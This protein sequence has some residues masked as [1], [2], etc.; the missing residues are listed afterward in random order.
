MSHKK[1]ICHYFLYCAQGGA[2]GLL[3]AAWLREIERHTLIPIAHMASVVAGASV[4]AIHAAALTLRHPDHPESPAYSAEDY[5]EIFKEDLPK[6]LPHDPW[7]YPRQVLRTPIHLAAQYLSRQARWMFGSSEQSPPYKAHYSTDYPETRLSTLFNGARVSDALT[8]LAISAHR[9]SPYPSTA[10]DFLSLPKD[11]DPEKFYHAFHPG[12]SEA[13]QAPF[14]ALS[15]IPLHQAVMASIVCPTIFKSYEIPGHGI[16]TDMGGVNSPAGMISALKASLPPEDDIHF[17][18]LG[19]ASLDR[20]IDPEHYNRSNFLATITPMT[21]MA[22]MHVSSQCLQAL[23][24]VIGAN[25]VT[26][27][28]AHTAE[29]RD[30]LDT[31]PKGIA[32]LEDLA[33]KTISSHR[34]RF[35]TIANKMGENHLR[36][37]QATPDAAFTR[38]PLPSHSADNKPSCAVPPQHPPTIPFPQEGAYCPLPSASHRHPYPAMA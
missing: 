16:F 35:E 21:D 30:I 2:F 31:S 11:F 27:L 33:E 38:P 32:A 20:R 14:R 12:I 7:F 37:T 15:N 23:R 13:E 34:T 10:C 9:L 29:I 19:T 6:F 36:T 18:W 26:I 3:N 1:G 28:E 24:S 22:N 25:N 4:G 8:G 17:V 5:Y